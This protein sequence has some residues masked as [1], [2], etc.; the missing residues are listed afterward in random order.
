MV[1]IKEGRWQVDARLRSRR[2]LGRCRQVWLG[3]PHRAV[4]GWEIL[5]ETPG[6]A[7]TGARIQKWQRASSVPSEQVCPFDNRNG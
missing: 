7:H 6:M 3:A 1:K 2:L 4:R 5:R